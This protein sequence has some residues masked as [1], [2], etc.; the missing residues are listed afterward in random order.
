VRRTPLFEAQHSE[1]Y[2]RQELIA[3]YQRVFDVNLIVVI[4]QIVP[5]AVTYLEELLYDIDTERP[6]HVLLASPGGDGEVALRMV[7]AMQLR[8]TELTV[9]VPDQAKSAATLIC[10]GA[11]R[12]LMGPAG[13]L[14]PVDPQLPGDTDWNLVSC[15]DLVRAVD[16]AEA[17]VMRAPDAYPLFASLLSDVSMVMLEQARSAI[18]RSESLVREALAC[19]ATRTAEEVDALTGRLR[20][21]LIDEPATHSALVSAPAALRH[22]LPVEMAD[23]MSDQWRLIWSLWVRYVHLGCFPVGQCSVYEG[24]RASHVMQPTTVPESPAAQ[25][26]DMLELLR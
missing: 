18:D 5:D 9:I 10:L 22:G 17:R 21:P 6:L 3:D 2:V 7:R 24:Q 23:P 8:C 25:A 16:E 12:I 19:A 15:K 1:R 20:G 26:A 4:D 11:D 13:D 14:G